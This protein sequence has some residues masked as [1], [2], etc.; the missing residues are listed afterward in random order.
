METY[1]ARPLG[2]GG[3]VSISEL[4]WGALVFVALFVCCLL[5][6]KAIQ[7]LRNRMQFNGAAAGAGDKKD[8]E[9]PW[10][11]AISRPSA[12]YFSSVPLSS[13]WGGFAGMTQREQEEL[14]STHA[15]R[16]VRKA[17]RASRKAREQTQKHQNKS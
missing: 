8:N 10:D 2:A 14:F 11:N 9:N 7:W 17:M 1:A 12:D 13:S 16:D 5:A 4:F 6:W 3:N 15:P